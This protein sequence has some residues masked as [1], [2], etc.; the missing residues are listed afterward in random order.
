MYIT[1]HAIIP[2]MNFLLCMMT[3][4]ILYIATSQD[5]FIADVE[6]RVD[7]LPQTVE[8]TGGEDFGYAKFYDSVDCLVMGRKTY[9]QILSFGAWPYSG[10][11]TFVFTSQ[12]QESVNEEILFFTDNI[13]EFYQK[14]AERNV[15][16]LWLVGGS[17][18]LDAFL[19]AG[20]VDEAIVT[21]FPAILQRGIP[22]NIRNMH[23]VHHIE[24]GNGMYQ[25]YYH[26]NESTN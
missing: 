20:K 11:T 21:V 1:N 6:G 22:L 24:Y 26:N 9:E 14:L 16:T 4:T 12:P 25:D 17:Q 2:S 3:K 8:E 19:Q 23:K 13:K 15:K 7:W 10:K 18:L 5:G